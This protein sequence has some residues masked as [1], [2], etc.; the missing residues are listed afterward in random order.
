MGTSRTAL[1]VFGSAFGSP[2][3]A[4]IALL[5]LTVRAVKST[6]RHV[7]ASNSSGRTYR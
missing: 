4:S 5:T 3:R 6:S 1:A 7:S 2:V